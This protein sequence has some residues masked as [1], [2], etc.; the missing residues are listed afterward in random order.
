MRLLYVT[1]VRLEGGA[2]GERHVEATVRRMSA[3]GHPVTLL[4][5]GVHSPRGVEHLRPSWS[6]PGLRLEAALARLVV[7]ATTR[8]VPEA[9]YVRLSAT[10]SL[11]PAALRALGIPYVVELNGPILD[12]MRA[13][14]RSEL[15]V[16]A[17]RQSL[18]QAVRGARGMVAV[19]ASIAAHARRHLGAEAVQVIENGADVDVATPGDRREARRRLG[20]PE[21]ASLVGFAGSLAPELHLTALFEAIERTDAHLAVA[22]D[23][24]QEPA[25]RAFQGRHPDRVHWLGA[26][27]HPQALDLVRALDVCVNVRPRWTG[28]RPIE[29]LVMGRRCALVP[30]DGTERLLRVTQHLPAFVHVAETD[31]PHALTSAVQ[32]ALQA[33]RE[34]G[35]PSDD[36]LG[37]VRREL[38]WDRT[39]ERIL[40][41]VRG[42]VKVG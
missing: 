15:R 18:R 20:L 26:V 37:P 34:H 29:A 30:A 23:G 3:A 9:A 41:V 27:P 16:R 17:V 7:A 12:E 21:D 40:S 33:E 13:R 25:L 11:V 42:V 28:M 10:S 39:V 2:G 22:G 4:A 31:S 1:Q 32:A 8:R 5:P 24:A 35:P 38:S 19:H 6:Q 36:D 14:G